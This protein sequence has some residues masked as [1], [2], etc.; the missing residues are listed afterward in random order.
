MN[1]LFEAG[2]DKISMNSAA[3]KNPDII[4]KA[5]EKFGAQAVVVAV[6][7]KKIT[8]KT[9]HVFTRGGSYDTRIDAVEWIKEAQKLGA[10]ELLITSMDRD[11]TKEGFDTEFLQTIK[12]LVTVPVIAS[13]GAGKAEDFGEVFRENLADAGLAASIFH[14]GEIKIPDL[15]KTLKEKGISVRI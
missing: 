2:A 4:Q 9:W 15:K 10:G 11:G 1:V 5:A 8:E 12:P 3:V 14:F 6:D 7:V 13:G